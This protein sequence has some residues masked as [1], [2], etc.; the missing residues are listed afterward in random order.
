MTL[1]S[2]TAKTSGT[3]RFL[4]NMLVGAVC[5]LT[6]VSA[7]IASADRTY[8]TVVRETVY[9]SP[10]RVIVSPRVIVPVNRSVYVGI[11]S[12]SYV[13]HQPRQTV[14]YREVTLHHGR[15]DE[16]YYRD[17]GYRRGNDHHRDY[18]HRAHP[19][20]GYSDR[21]HGYGY[22]N[23]E[24]VRGHWSG[25]DRRRDVIYVEK[26]GRRNSSYRET[27]RRSVEIRDR[28]R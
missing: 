11:G 20:W 13:S 12:G 24:P 1:F 23:K 25:S 6:A 22:R 3:Q 10:S 18:D 14:I 4:H 21:G 28:S 5:V 8:T 7:N 2:A 19:V 15:H 9:H 26:D 17:G 27:E 16:D